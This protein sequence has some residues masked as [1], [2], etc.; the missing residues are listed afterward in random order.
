MTERQ[1]KKIAVEFRSKLDR[2]I[3]R[4]NAIAQIIE[5]YGIDR[6]SLYRWCARFGVST[7]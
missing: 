1:R 4:K 2:H 6:S 7:R 3:L 5:D